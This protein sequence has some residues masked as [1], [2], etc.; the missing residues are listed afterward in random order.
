MR[1]EPDSLIADHIFF[2]PRFNTLSYS[3]EEI[4]SVDSIKMVHIR[5]TLVN[6]FGEKSYSQTLMIYPSD[7]QEVPVEP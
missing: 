6:S 7:E 2:D 4:K 5:I 3:G 1:V